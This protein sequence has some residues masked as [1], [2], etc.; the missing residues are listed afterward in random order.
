MVVPDCTGLAYIH[1]R[2]ILHTDIGCHNLLLDQHNNLKL[3]DFAGSSIDGE[4]PTVCCDV[5][6]QP[7]TDDPTYP[8]TI[9]TE[10]FA[11]GS[12]LYEIWTG[13]KPYQDKSDEDVI[14]CFRDSQFPDV[15]N[16]PPA[17]V[18]SKCWR[19]SYSNATEVVNDLAHFEHSYQERPTPKP[20][21]IFHG[22]T[23]NIYGILPSFPPQFSPL[24][25]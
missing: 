13:R 20:L 1:S 10:L 17:S 7:Y 5:R 14:R 4:E 18:I 23:R 9:R 8:V 3:C 11:L 2:K 19:G 6:Y 22:P 16:L 24:C 21:H 12:T 15:E 25:C